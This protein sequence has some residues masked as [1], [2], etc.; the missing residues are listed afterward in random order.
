M[1]DSA[2][3]MS[4]AGKKLKKLYNFTRIAHLLH[5]CA[6]CVRTDFKIIDEVIATTKATI[7]KNK[8]RK[9]DFYDAGLPFHPDL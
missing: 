2:R 8:D 1:T 3:Y 5:N 7:I 4:L 6:M 9:K